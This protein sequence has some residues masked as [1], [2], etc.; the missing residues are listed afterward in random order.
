[1][2]GVVVVDGEQ[3]WLT[4]YAC[5][6]LQ[7]DRARLADWVRRS[8]QAGHAG[9]VE[10]CPRCAAGGSGFPHV[11]PPVRRGRVAGYV[12]EQLMEAEEYTSTSTRGGVI[13]AGV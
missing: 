1:V 6:Q 10:A 7:V 2:S 8:K 13:R 3:R 4:W 12:G 5:K 11:D 9:P